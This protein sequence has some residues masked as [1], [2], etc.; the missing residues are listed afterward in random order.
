VDPHGEGVDA[1]PV[2]VGRATSSVVINIRS[3]RTYASDGSLGIKS[4]KCGLDLGR[5][6]QR[7]EI[8]ALS[9]SDGQ[10]GSTALPR[11]RLRPGC[12]VSKLQ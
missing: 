12:P 10:H 4:K 5:V 7:A 2:E 11:K 8:Q 1:R 6:T 9:Q 3:N